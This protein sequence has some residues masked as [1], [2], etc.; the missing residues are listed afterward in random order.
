MKKISYIFK[1][2]MFIVVVALLAS[3]SA[4]PSFLPANFESTVDA[5]ERGKIILL[6]SMQKRDPQNR[7]AQMTLMKVVVR[8][9]WQSQAARLFTPITES[10]QQLQFAFD[11]INEDVFMK[12]LSGSENGNI[13]GI[14][15]GKTYFETKGA[16]KEQPSKRVEWYLPPVK[17]Y[18]LWPQMMHTFSNIVYLGTADLRMQHYYKVFISDRN[19][20]SVGQ[21]DEYLVWVN[22][23][24]SR[25][26][27][28]EFTLRQFN[29]S[30]RG[31]VQYRDYREADGVIFPH[32]I[33]LLDAIESLNY[34]HRFYVQIISLQ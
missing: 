7:W 17:N 32:E 14:K 20:E 33:T 5:S 16:R 22:R 3:C 9:I 13:I 6:S 2:T 23:Q 24:T 11:L 8:D 21:G 15:N 31:V 27:F 19:G 26:E 4:T 1:N 12:F 18:F 10:E 30:Y 29:K 28:I 34:S 25:I